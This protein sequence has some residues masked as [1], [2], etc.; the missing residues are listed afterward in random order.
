[1]ETIFDHNPTK[2]ELSELIGDETRDEYIQDMEES[3][4]SPKGEN[5]LFI[6]LLYEMRKDKKTAKKYIAMVPDL[7]RQW[8]LGNDCRMI[9]FTPSPA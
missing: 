9:P 7:Y 4:L 1:M 2:E 8:K 3:M 5:L 6:A